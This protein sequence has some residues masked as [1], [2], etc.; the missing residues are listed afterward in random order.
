MS[1]TTSSTQR[2]GTRILCTPRVLCILRIPG[3]RRHIPADT[4]ATTGTTVAP[5]RDRRRRRAFPVGWI[6]VLLLLLVACGPPE[7]DP[8]TAA[9]VLDTSAEALVEQGRERWKTRRPE[10]LLAARDLFRQAID[11]D[12]GLAAAWSGL[13]DASA[14]LGL[15]SVEPAPVVMPEALRAADRALAL[16]PDNAATH[17]SRGLALYLHDWDF[18]AAEAAFRRALELDPELIN[19]H[20]WFGMML[21]VLGRHD[22]ALTHMRVAAAAAPNSALLATKVGTLLLTAGRLEDA[23]SVLLESQARFPD[24]VLPSRELGYVALA[25]HRPQIAAS[26]FVDALRLSG[27]GRD[28]GPDD[29]APMDLDEMLETGDPKLLVAL[30]LAMKRGDLRIRGEL[31]FDAQGTSGNPDALDA[32]DVAAAVRSRADHESMSPVTRARLEV[33]VGPHDEALRWLERAY[34]ARDP[35]L[36]YLRTKPSFEELENEPDYRELCRRIGIS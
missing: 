2:I 14:L 16:D 15:Y 29:S 31:T 27:P 30:A 24:S 10:D 28:R 32:D 26:H 19:G 13:A 9:P 5:G 20:H 4:G 33:V 6:A 3:A 8:R 34:T 11:L 18:V 12:A 17:A 36:V 21:S 23:R 7:P 35:G 22:E 25:M 1:W